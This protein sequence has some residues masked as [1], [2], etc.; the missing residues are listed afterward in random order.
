VRL[1]LYGI[2][3]SPELVGIGKY[4]GELASWLAE[5]GDEVR[6]ITAPPYYPAWRVQAPYSGWHYQR[7]EGRVSAVLRCPLWVPAKPSGLTH[8]LHLLSFALSS[9]IPVLWQATWRPDIVLVIE[10]P[11]FCAPAAWLTARLCGAKACLHVQDFEVD[12]AFD[13]L[14]RK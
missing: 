12:A 4:S 11:F 13:W 2:N 5:Q 6:V 8:I 3:F 14:F 7:E 10:P 9:F 1:L